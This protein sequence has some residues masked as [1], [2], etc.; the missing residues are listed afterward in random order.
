MRPI[1]SVRQ[2]D[3]DDVPI[4]AV[5]TDHE[6]EHEH[7]HDHDH[8]DDRDGGRVRAIAVVMAVAAI[9]VLRLALGDGYKS[10][11]RVG[12]RW[13]LVASAIV[14]LAIIA[15]DRFNSRRAVGHQEPHRHGLRPGIYLL[16]PVAL[17]I[18]V[19]PQPLGSF[20][21]ERNNVVPSPTSPFPELIASAGPAPMTLLEFDQRA[22]DRE[23]V[24][25][26]TARV[27]LTGFVMTGGSLRIARFRVACCAADGQAAVV[28]LDGVDVR[29]GADQ[30]V[31]VVGT[32]GG[33]QGDTPVLRVTDLRPISQ[34]TDPYEPA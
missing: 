8:D 14:L 15:A 21:A 12:M 31:T 3:D 9:V 10:F 13:P 7:D 24:S 25:F 6:H 28:A 27:Q 16:I 2:F 18:A 4:S 1:T 34:P 33:M 19:A 5:A 22:I 23:G 11:V 29:P 17:A 32:F 20:A 26:G 30:W